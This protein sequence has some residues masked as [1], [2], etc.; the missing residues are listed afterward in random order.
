MTV[1]QLIPGESKRIKQPMTANPSAQ[2][3]IVANLVANVSYVE[4]FSGTSYTAPFTLALNVAQPVYQPA[5]PTKTP[6]PITVERP[7]LTITGYDTDVDP[8]Q[9]G[10]PFTLKLEARNLGNGDAKGVT[11]I[12][13]GGSGS[14]GGVSGTPEP[15]GISGSS[16]DFANFAPLKSSNIHFIGDVPIDQSITIEQ[17]LIVNT[18]TSPGA[19]SVKFSFTYV[20]GR[21]NRFV[22]D[23]VITLLVYQLPLVDVT[24]YQ[25]PGPFFVGQPGPLPIQI[26][27]LSRKATILGN[28]KATVKEGG[29]V[30]NNVTLIGGMDPGGY[31]TL[32]AMLVPEKAGPMDIDISVNYTDDFNQPK[33][34]E[35]KLRVNVQEMSMEPGMSGGDPTGGVPG[36]KPG[37]VVIP[38]D[39][40]PVAPETFWQKVTR[41]A[42]GM[43]GLDSGVPQP[44]AGPMLPVEGGGGGPSGG[45]PIVIPARPMKGG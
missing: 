43:I 38:G 12:M 36:G 8:L 14:A 17:P 30:T 31:F 42:K 7:Q 16:G 10:V 5:S 34:I 35:A 13:G 15:G 24:F 39:A 21:G 27:N 3:G 19:F 22:D 4:Q 33:T 37:E 32:D 9:P 18:S 29:Q 25:D 45:K 23:Q 20:D 41:F 1:Y 26:T 44:A 2:G 11:M 6:T 28:M 40:G